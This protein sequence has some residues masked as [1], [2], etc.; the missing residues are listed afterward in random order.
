MPARPQNVPFWGQER[1]VFMFLCEKNCA[2]GHH[3]MFGLCTVFYQSR[4]YKISALASIRENGIPHFL[5]TGGTICCWDTGVR[6]SAL[7]RGITAT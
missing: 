2:C 4:M 1:Y 5:H 6:I 7:T 3:L